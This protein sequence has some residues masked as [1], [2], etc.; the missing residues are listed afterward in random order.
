LSVTTTSR[1][2]VAWDA[3]PLVSLHEDVRVNCVCAWTHE[4]LHCHALDGRFKELLQDGWRRGFEVA[5]QGIVALVRAMTSLLIFFENSL[6]LIMIAILDPRQARTEGTN[7]IASN[8]P[9]IRILVVVAKTFY[10]NRRL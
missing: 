1:D 3:D 5:M 4:T 8:I 10:W 6:A 9:T 7:I 2:R